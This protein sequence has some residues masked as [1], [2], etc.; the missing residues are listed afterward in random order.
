MTH[1]KPY[2]KYSAILDRG[3]IEE[4]E[5]ISLCKILNGY[6]KTTMTAEEKEGIE[7]RIWDNH[8]NISESQ[9]EKGFNFLMNKW[10]TPRGIERK[11]NP[12]GYRE[13]EALKNFSHFTLDGFYNNSTVYAQD[14]GFH[15]YLP[16]YSVHSKNGYGF[17]YYYD[18]TV[19]I[20]G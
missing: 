19:N 15:N 9:T 6:S 4:G 14:S 8:V 3:T 18:G 13:E 17:Q 16:L 7:R 20:I 10:K 1:S 12:F 5:I 11:N 2:K